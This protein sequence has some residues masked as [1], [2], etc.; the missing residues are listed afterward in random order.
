MFIFNLKFIA[1]HRIFTGEG[2]ERK[3]K[4]ANGIISGLL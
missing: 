4:P 1:L 2:I 3:K